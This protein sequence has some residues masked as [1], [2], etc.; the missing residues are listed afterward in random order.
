GAGRLA[1]GSHRMGLF[2]FLT[3]KRRIRLQDVN[4]GSPEFNANPYPFYAR[5]RAES[6]IYRMNRFL[7]Q[8]A[9]LATRYDDAPMILK[10]ER[11]VKVAANA[12]ILEQLANQPW[13]RKVK[14]F[15]SLQLNML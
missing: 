1:A 14:L 3:R 4:L 8:Q 7:G 13:F 12:M 15:Q 10:D 2:W 6:P 5:L 11:F 9:W